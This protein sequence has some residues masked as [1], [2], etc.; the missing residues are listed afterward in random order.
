MVTGP[1]T[2]VPGID[3]VADLAVCGEAGTLVVQAHR[4]DAAPQD[5][6]SDFRYGRF[7][8]RV[9]LPPRA[10]AAMSRLLTTTGS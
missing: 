3:P 10:D 4:T 2:T 7:A 5:H 6:Q 9:T 8:R 1:L